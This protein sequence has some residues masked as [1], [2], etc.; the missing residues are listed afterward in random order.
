MSQPVALFGPTVAD[1]TL[2]WHAPALEAGTSGTIIYTVTI[3]SDATGPLNNQAEISSNMPD[4]NPEDN[5]TSAET[6]VSASADLEIVKAADSQV[7]AAGAVLTYTV[8]YTNSGP[9][10]AVSVRITDTLPGDVAFGGIVSAQP[11]LPGFEYDGG[12]LAWYTPTLTAMTSGS[13]VFT[14]TVN[15]GAI[16]SLVNGV[17]ITSSTPDADLLNNDA[18][19]T[20]T[21]GDPT[22]ATIY[23]YVFEDADGDREWDAGEPPIPDVEVA[24]DGAITTT[25]GEGGLYL[26]LVSEPGAHTVV[27]TDPDGYLSS[28]PNVA[29][30][31][32]ILGN[33]YRVDFG[34]APAASCTCPPDGYESD[35]ERTQAKA[36]GLELRQAHDF[37]DDAT[38]W[39]YFSAEA[40]RTYT[41]TTSAGGPDWYWG[42]RTDTNLA[43]YDA[44][45]QL[46]VANDDYE[47]TDDH[48][49]QIVWEAPRAGDYYLHT[50]NRAELTGCLTSYEVWI[51]QSELHR[52]YLPLISRNALQSPA[53]Q[54]YIYVPLVTRNALQS[55]GD[56]ADQD[57]P[58]KASD[59]GTI[60]VPTGVIAHTC[61]DA[62]EVDDTWM[63]AK[64]IALGVV[65][66]HSFD[67]NPEQFAADKDF[68]WFDLHAGNTIT[69]TVPT[70]T[71][72]M[73]L[74]EL[75]DSRGNTLNITGTDQL[76]WTAPSIGRYHLGVSPR[77]ADYGCADEVGYTLVAEARLTEIIYLPLVLR[78]WLSP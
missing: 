34:D 3:A 31:D 18:G 40:G 42:R 12:Q 68:V 71:Q 9:S 56:A 32:S 66:V 77:T 72:T 60:D 75:Y 50:T 33:S 28:T 25:S 74:L 21:V 59:M 54:Y 38:D 2:S 5:S 7:I 51:S 49:S 20:T 64:P 13:V 70:V 29:Q 17:T 53:D 78:S 61:S 57:G 44:G 46:L 58:T 73:T 6:I 8:A 55:S 39:S 43:L 41:I 35:D 16:G 14:V 62:Y 27:E 10:D 1:Q 4:T 63:Q 47:G 19:T 24:L 52:L 67:S 15:P 37:C 26:F 22:R 48:S 30:I 36:L 69:F 76:V 45:G 23:G 65:Q 11:A